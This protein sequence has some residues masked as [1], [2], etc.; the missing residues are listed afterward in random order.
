ML[1]SDFA[2]SY[3]P[4][5]RP[6]TRFPCLS[7]ALFL[8]L[9]PSLSLS[10]SLSPPLSFPQDDISIRFG[11]GSIEGQMA[12]DDFHLGLLVVKGQTFAEITDEEG[13]VRWRRDE[14]RRRGRAEVRLSAHC[15]PPPKNKR[16]KTRSL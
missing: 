9:P 14:E 15:P 3:F 12:T 8:S 11:T 7:L 16:S 4:K 13:D 10:L 2:T 1:R 5:L 6:L